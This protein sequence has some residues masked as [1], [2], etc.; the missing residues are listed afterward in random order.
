MTEDS[1]DPADP[2]DSVGSADPADSVGYADALAELESILSELEA[3]TVDVDRLATQV[4]R[5]SELIRIC[6][7]RLRDA[8]VQV[9]E[10]VAELEDG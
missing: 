2:A 10:I 7:G 3:D 9:E 5:A 6:R 8:R 1:A 4:Q